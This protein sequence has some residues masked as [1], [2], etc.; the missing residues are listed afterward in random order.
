[1]TADNGAVPG[2]AVAIREATAED[3]D[4]VVAGYD[5][6]LA[7]PGSVPQGWDHSVARLRLI[8]AI[9]APRSLVLLAQTAAGELVG[10]CTVYLDILSVRWGQRAWVEDLAVA[11]A[12]RS[13]GTGRELLATALSWAAE[14]GATHMELESGLGREDAHRFYLRENATQNAFSFR[15]AL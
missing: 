12:A 11:P 7:P 5:W 2:Q 9:V 8:H 6:L 10:L 13:R 14:N 3:A 4:R 15:W 1:M